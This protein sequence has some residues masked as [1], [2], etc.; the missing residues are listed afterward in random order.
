MRRNGRWGATSEETSFHIR[1]LDRRRMTVRNRTCETKILQNELVIQCSTIDRDHQLVRTSSCGTISPF[2]F[3]FS[4]SL[5]K[6]ESW[7]SWRLNSFFSTVSLVLFWEFLIT[8]FRTSS[9]LG[10][11]IRLIDPSRFSAICCQR[12]IPFNQRTLR[13][14]VSAKDSRLAD[15]EHP[16]ESWNHQI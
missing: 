3:T 5:V 11:L 13:F 1:A 2:A 12:E 6:K 4:A 14:S 15:D 9:L 8:I 16:V 10:C 7:S